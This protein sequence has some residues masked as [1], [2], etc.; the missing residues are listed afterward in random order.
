M[1]EGQYV[2][3]KRHYGTCTYADGGVYTGTDLSLCV[4]YH[5]ICPLGEWKNDMF[6]GKGKFAWKDGGLFEGDWVDDHRVYGTYTQSN[7][8]IYQG[9]KL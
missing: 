9:T 8:D 5:S 7:G 2:E 6:N 4:Y 3:D 1:F